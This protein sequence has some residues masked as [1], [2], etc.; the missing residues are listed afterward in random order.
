MDSLPSVFR[1]S[2]GGKVTTLCRL[3]G[4][5][6]GLSALLDSLDGALYGTMANGG[7]FAAGAVFR[8]TKDCSL[9]ILHSF[10]RRPVGDRPHSGLLRTRDGSLWGTTAERGGIIYRIGP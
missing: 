9:T 2:T 6:G 7:S 4:A 8:L 1:M 3:P 5:A 10:S